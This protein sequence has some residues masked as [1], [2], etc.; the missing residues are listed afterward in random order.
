MGR[1]IHRVGRTAR[2]TSGGRALLMLLPSEEAAVSESLK[3]AGVPFK[4]L[5]VNKKQA[6]KA[7][8]LYKKCQH[9]V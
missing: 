5:T 4:K 2:Y 7:T 9:A 8:N 3:A 1:Y 6:S